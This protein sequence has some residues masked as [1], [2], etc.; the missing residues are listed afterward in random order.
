MIDPQKPDARTIDERAFGSIHDNLSR[1]GDLNF[2]NRL[3][4]LQP[5]FLEKLP[6]QAEDYRM[7]F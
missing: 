6:R 5:M 7:I 1:L 2:L 4:K 3:F